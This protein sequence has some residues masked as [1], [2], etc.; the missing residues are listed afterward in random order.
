M[1]F[2]IVKYEAV[3]TIS[4]VPQPAMNAAEGRRNHIHEQ[5]QDER[6][7][8]AQSLVNDEETHLDHCYLRGFP[9]TEPARPARSCDPLE[10]LRSPCTLERAKL[11]RFGVHRESPQ[12]MNSFFG[13]LFHRHSYV[14]KE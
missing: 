10:E 2:E 12:W 3:K 1:T 11:N 8:M 9:V 5:K 13:I 6:L 7:E 14:P 4:A